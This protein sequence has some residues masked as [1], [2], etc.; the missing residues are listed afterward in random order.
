M[1]PQISD[2]TYL[3]SENSLFDKDLK[4]TNSKVKV[5]DVDNRSLQILPT[6]CIISQ[7]M[8]CITTGGGNVD[9]EKSL[10]YGTKSEVYHY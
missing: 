7:P 9:L 8:A 4:N 3:E 2:P 5:H 10:M 1:N 6:S